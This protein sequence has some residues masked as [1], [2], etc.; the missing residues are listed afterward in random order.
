MLPGLSVVSERRSSGFHSSIDLQLAVLRHLPTPLIVLS[1]QRTAIFANRA[2]ERA[3]GSRDPIQSPSK[4]ILGRAPTDLGIKLLYN[5]EWDVVLSRLAAAHDQAVAEGNEGPVHEIDAVISTPSLS[6][7]E[8]HFRV[9]VAILTADDGA[10][11]MLSIERSP[12][13]EKPMIPR[14]EDQICSTLVETVKLDQRPLDSSRSWRDIGKIK[15]AV[16]DSCNMAG[17]ILTADEQFYL[18][19]KK[20][21]EVLG[22]MMGGA[23]GCEG[24]AVRT[25]L[26][27]WDENFVNKL[28]PTEFP[29]MKLVRAR[30]PF[31]GYRCGFIHAMTG[32]R[33]VASIDGECL[34]D[35]DTREFIGGMCWCRDLQVYSDFL[36][37]KLQRR[38]ESHKTIC[39]L[40]PHLVWTTTTDGY[41]DY[42]SNRVSLLLTSATGLD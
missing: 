20:A 3:L 21:R 38:L 15:R 23:D 10:H 19:N 40:M 6:F 24:L 12:H 14:T 39:D 5:R 9:L 42:F 11:F 32:V 26:E 28:G 35:D 41:C 13:I 17:F 16:F 7:A 37:D 4:G 30:K 29:G 2:A 18:S 31:T 1:P 27:V 36:E 34:Y 22:D 8:R 33:L 25:E